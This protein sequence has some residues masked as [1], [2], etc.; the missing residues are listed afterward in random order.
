[1]NFFVLIIGIIYWN[2]SNPSQP[3][4]PHLFLI[5]AAGSAFCQFS[6]GIAIRALT[7]GPQGPV[8]SIM[9]SCTLIFSIIEAIRTKKLPTYFEFI[10]LALGL[11]G[12]LEMVIPEFFE[13]IV[14]FWR[15]KK[16]GGNSNQASADDS[17]QGTM[18]PT[19]GD[20]NAAD[21]PSFVENKAAMNRKT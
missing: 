12:A 14:C 6:I 3:F 7:T 9:V 8:C 15:K 21:G 11:I 4:N 20:K 13:R 17:L 1:M 19:T 10:A 5:G 16:Q 2:S 18:L